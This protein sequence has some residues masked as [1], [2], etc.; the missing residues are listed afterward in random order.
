MRRRWILVATVLFAMTGLAR[1]ATPD[2]AEQVR[3]L[4]RG[5]NILGYDPLWDSPA[6]ARFQPLDYARIRAGGFQTVRVNLQAFSHMNAANQLDPRWLSTLDGVVRQA[7]AAGLMVILD[8]HDFIP[9][10]KDAA[11]CR[12]RLLAFWTQ[13][14]PRYRNAPDSVLF[15]ILNEPNDQEK[16]AVWNSLLADALALI[17]RSNPTRTVII[18][19][20]YSN[21]IGALGQLVL[22]DAD[23]NII[24]TVHYY[25]PLAFTHQGASWT[26]PSLEGKT[27]VTWG[28]PAERAAIGHDLDRVADWAR[29]HDRPILIGEFGAFDKGDMASRAAWTS[30]VARAAEARG[31]AWCYWQFDSNFLA[32]DVARGDWVAPIHDALVPR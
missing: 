21:T 19:P 8:E 5:I 30:T 25:E 9:C 22:P 2:A 27:G 29:L 14:A 10:A 1:A 18:G 24:V 11:L 6:E 16:P 15:E 4:G 20:A 28:T 26:T 3:R 12:T 7:E 17:R 32:F 23:R 13:I 31:F